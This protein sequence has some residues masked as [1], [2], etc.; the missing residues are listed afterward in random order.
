MKFCDIFDAT[1]WWSNQIDTELSYEHDWRH[2]MSMSMSIMQHSA[3]R[4]TR[5]AKRIS[6]TN[7]DWQ[8]R[9]L[10]EDLRAAAN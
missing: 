4:Q 6:D 10:K 7:G 2:M 9:L 3:Y 1:V 8:Q 5:G